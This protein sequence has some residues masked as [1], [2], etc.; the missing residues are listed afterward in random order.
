[1]KTFQSV[2]KNN[3]FHVSVVFS[4]IT[5]DMWLDFIFAVFSGYMSA[6]FFQVQNLV[7]KITESV[8]NFVFKQFKF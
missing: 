2:L 8:V 4:E 6:R 5:C 3:T 7:N 1:M